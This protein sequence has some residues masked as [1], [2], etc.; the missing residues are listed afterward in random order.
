MYIH[1]LPVPTH[2]V[3]PPQQN[4]VL[5]KMLPEKKATKSRQRSDIEVQKLYTCTTVDV[6][7]K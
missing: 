4:A 5:L 6:N 1:F 2:L 3:F 7:K